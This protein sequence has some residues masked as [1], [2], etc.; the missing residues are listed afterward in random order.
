[1]KSSFNLDHQQQ[2]PESKIVVALERISEAF[3]VLLWNEGK[4]YGLSPIQV[5]VL[6]FLLFHTRE[7]STV[8]YLAAEF[9]MSR[10]TIS[11]SVKSL[12]HKKFIIKDVDEKDTRSSG[13]ILT[14]VGRALAQQ[15]SLFSGVLER[16]LSQLTAAQKETMLNGLLRLIHD[17]NQAGIITLQ[18]MCFNCRYYRNK[19]GGHYCNLLNTPLA[20]A[21][22]R[23][24]CPEH[25]LSA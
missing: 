17:L 4:E 14:S 16:P 24:D 10:A 6:I 23:V 11:E 15:L 7:Q 1:M 21:D 8:S 19:N 2:S 3:R 9:N 18:R 25:E 12:L 20:N 22:L 13:I 5:Q